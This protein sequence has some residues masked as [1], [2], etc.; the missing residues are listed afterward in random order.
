MKHNEIIYQIFPRNYSK[1]G[2]FSQ[3]NKEKFYVIE[4]NFEDIDNVYEN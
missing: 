4:N 3:I 1:E 2:T